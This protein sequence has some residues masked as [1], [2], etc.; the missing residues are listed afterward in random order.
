MPTPP[1][2]CPAAAKRPFHY[3]W[4]L[5]PVLCLLVSWCLTA[6]AAETDDKGLFLIA[7]EHLNGTGFQQTV[8]FVTQLSANGAT[9]LAINRPTDIPINHAVPKGHPLSNYNG[10]LFLGGP[11]NPSNTFLILQTKQPTDDMYPVVNDIYFT[12]AHADFGLTKI[13]N[14]RIFAGYS[15]WGP[16]QLQAEI[17]RG[18]W[19]T[20]KTDPNIVFDADTANLWHRLYQMKSANWI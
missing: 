8:I 7:T 6:R 20:I 18:D 19:L 10:P 2:H 16:G 17:D 11:V 13:I 12:T 4:L 5:V 15:G 9:G 14:L 3:H 1:L